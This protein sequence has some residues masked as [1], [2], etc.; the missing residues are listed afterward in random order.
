M[1]YRGIQYQVVQAANPT[2]W[3]WT[4]TIDGKCIKM[5]SSFSRLSATRLAEVAIEK[6]L[7]AVARQ[8]PE[9]PFHLQV[10]DSRHSSSIARSASHVCRGSNS[11]VCLLA[12]YVRCTLKSGRRQVAS[13]TNHCLSRRSLG[14]DE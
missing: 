13:E 2:G 6:H 5:G 7:K 12:R 11:E 1:E 14:S 9:L 10:S 3:K 4:V 8:S